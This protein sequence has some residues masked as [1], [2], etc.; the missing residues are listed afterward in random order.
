MNNELE[1]RLKEIKIENIAFGIFIILIILAYYANDLEID[2]FLN[3]N[4]NSQR[5]YYYT[6]IFIFSVVVIISAYYFYQAYQEII[7]IKN[8]GSLKKQ[9]YANL[10][11]IASGAA[12]IAGLIYLYIAITDTEI[13]A[14]ISL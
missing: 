10:D 3:N 1:K 2:F 12:L 4:K 9:K 11:L 5:K 8:D 14:E 7:S 13:E 6:M